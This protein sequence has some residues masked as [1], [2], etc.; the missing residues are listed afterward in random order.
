MS[1]AEFESF[2]NQAKSHMMTLDDVNYILN[3]D[4]VDSNVAQS[5]KKDMLNQMKNVRNMPTSASGANSQGK[6]HKSADREVFENILGF[7]GGTDNL[8]G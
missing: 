1:E 7:D 2:K 4:K 8:F 5:T 6:G 3:R